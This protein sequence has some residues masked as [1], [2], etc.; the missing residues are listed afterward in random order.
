[1][2]STTLKYA[3]SPI[4]AKNPIQNLASVVG[5]T[6]RNCNKQKYNAL[7]TPSP[8]R[9]GLGRG[10]SGRD[11]A[12]FSLGYYS[13]D[14]QAIGQNG[15][16][17]LN[18]DLQNVY[19][20]GSDL[21]NGNISHMVTAIHQQNNP[22]AFTPVPQAT[23][24]RYDRLNR[25]KEM[26]AYQGTVSSGV[27]TAQ[28]TQT[29]ASA[30]KYDFNGNITELERYAG[31]TQIDDLEYFYNHDNHIAKTGLASNRLYRVNEDAASTSGDDL[32][33]FNYGKTFDKNDPSS[34]NYNYDPI[35]NLVK[36]TSEGISLI[37]W[38]VTSKVSDVIFKVDLPNNSYNLAFRYDPMGNR[39]AKIKK[40]HATLANCTTWTITWYARD[41]QGN[42]MAVYTKPENSTAFAATEFNIYG[43]SRIGMVTQPEEL[44]ESPSD[45][46]AFSQ[47]LGNKVYEFS[48]HLGNVLTTF[49]DRK[50]A[51]EGDPGFVAY[52]TSEILSTTDYYPFGFQMPGRVYE[53]DYRY[54]FNGQEKDNE[55]TGSGNSYTAEFWQ[56]DSRIGRRWNVDP[57]PSPSISNY[58]CFSL[59]PNYYSDPLG[60][61]LK[62]DGNTQ[63]NNDLKSIAGKYDEIV[64]VSDKENIK[65]NFDLVKGEGRFYNKKGEFN[66]KKFNR[67]KKRALKDIG[68]QTINSIANMPENI[69]YQTSGTVSFYQNG[70]GYEMDLSDLSGTSE[71]FTTGLS[72]VT[73]FSTQPRGDNYPDRIPFDPNLA[74]QIIVADGCFQIK[75]NYRD[76]STQEII[77][78]EWILINRSSVV[79]HE[80]RE[81]YYRVHE[82][83]D[84]PTA[85]QLSINDEGSH[86]GHLKPGNVSKVYYH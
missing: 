8:R 58:S 31:G 73:S 57:R 10:F 32:Q 54:G 75:K 63:S 81:M 5:E 50:I 13:G 55:I 77:R 16:D 27:W 59:N 41:A 51:T 24:Y 84:Y 38:T 45:P 47:T 86:Y 25:I 69:L 11:A 30:Y 56:Y 65:I 78:T 70:Q 39:I 82:K 44:D 85:H 7:Q 21:F 68:V 46:V 53:G 15:G 71:E 23:T 60:D 6:S 18:A 79:Y 42:V 36:D 26:K 40:P 76:E 12:G 72:G 14:Y 37:N 28:N 1:M 67:Y 35:G 2:P 17:F 20:S 43:S 3:Y 61:T 66:E 33:P 52:Y 29:F 19:S 4:G 34:W 83:K 80:L 49:S 48:N 22:P 64:D 9:G 62:S 74:G